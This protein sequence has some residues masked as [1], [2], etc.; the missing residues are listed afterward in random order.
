MTGRT[1]LGGIPIWWLIGLSAFRFRI[2]QTTGIPLIRSGREG[3][4]GRF[5]LKLFEL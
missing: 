5:I 1:K 2:S 4:L 3:K